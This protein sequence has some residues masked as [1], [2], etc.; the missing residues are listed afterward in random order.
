[1][2]CHLLWLWLHPNSFGRGVRR[3]RYASFPS[4]FADTSLVRRR[5]LRG[6]VAEFDNTKFFA[7]GRVVSGASGSATG[8]F[9]LDF[10]PG[11]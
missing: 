5:L 4:S 10:S 8:G 11:E 7:P 2:G 6:P 1:L 3:Q 9:R